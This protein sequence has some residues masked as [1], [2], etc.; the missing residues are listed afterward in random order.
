MGIS[1]P[2]GRPGRGRRE[3]PGPR[4]WTA[5]G[6]L[7]GFDNVRERPGKVVGAGDTVRLT[8]INNYSGHIL[9]NGV[10]VVARNKGGHKL[11][12]R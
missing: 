5:A 1:W 12:K 3:G 4:G 9:T 6:R 10:G 2:C 7:D 11:E 8:A